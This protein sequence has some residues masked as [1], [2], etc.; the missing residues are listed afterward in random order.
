MPSAFFSLLGL[1][2]VA[3]TT[4]L[5][6]DQGVR[7]AHAVSRRTLELAFGIILAL[8]SAPVPYA[9]LSG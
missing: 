8:V 4:V 2:L 5:A 6:T 3:P 9:I 1:V 7:L